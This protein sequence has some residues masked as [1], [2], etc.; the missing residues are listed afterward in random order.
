MDQHPVLVACPCALYC[1]NDA[2]RPPPGLNLKPTGLQPL[3]RVLDAPASPSFAVVCTAANGLRD[4]GHGSQLGTCR[5]RADTVSLSGNRRGRFLSLAGMRAGAR[6]SRGVSGPRPGHVPGKC[7]SQSSGLASAGL[8]VAQGRASA[9]RRPPYSASDR[10]EGIHTSRVP[11]LLS[12]GARGQEKI[13]VNPGLT[14]HAYL[15]FV[16]WCHTTDSSAYRSSQH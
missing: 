4:L 5:Q 15:T 2:R 10:R 13:P 1:T 6:C 11:M 8:S 12:C 14:F 3:P 9:A 7:R 16:L